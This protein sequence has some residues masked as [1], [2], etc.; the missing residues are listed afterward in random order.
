MSLLWTK[1]AWLSVTCSIIRISNDFSLFVSHA[2]RSAYVHT[3]KSHY[4]TLEIA[5]GSRTRV[6]KKKKNNNKTRAKQQSV[7]GENIVSDK[8]RHTDDL[9][10]AMPIVIFHFVWHFCVRWRTYKMWANA[11]AM[12]LLC[13]IRLVRQLDQHS[14]P[15]IVVFIVWNWSSS[16]LLKPVPP[17]QM[18]IDQS[19]VPANLP[20]T[21]MFCVQ[22]ILFASGSAL[23][24]ILRSLHGTEKIEC[25]TETEPQ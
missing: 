5:A 17:L 12:L 8:C 15:L 22:F 24:R 16:S 10:D 20:T 11:N 19:K 1:T 21:R 4:V 14:I 2:V 25:D 23:R 7:K 9:E 6:N 13:M 3:T 18:T